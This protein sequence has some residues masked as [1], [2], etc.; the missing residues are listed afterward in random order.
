MTELMPVPDVVFYL[1][2]DPRKL[3]ARHDFGKERFDRVAF[4]LAVKQA[5]GSSLPSTK[6]PGWLPIDADQEPSLIH[7]CILATLFS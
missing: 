4:Q 1:D 3:A 7:N 5:F 6:P 2:A